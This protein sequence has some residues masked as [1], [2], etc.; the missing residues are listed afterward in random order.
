MHDLLHISHLVP[1]RRIT[2]RITHRTAPLL[3]GVE[4]EHSTEQPTLPPRAPRRPNRFNMIIYN[5]QLTA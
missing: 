1:T 3:P 2:R 5:L 4:R